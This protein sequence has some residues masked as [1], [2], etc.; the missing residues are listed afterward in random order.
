MPDTKQEQQ[1]LESFK[2]DAFMSIYS[3]SANLEVTPWD[4][5]FVFGA[6]ISQG[7]N[8]SPK[9]ESRVEVVMSPQHAK[10]MLNVLSTH[11]QQY[12]KQVGEVK[13][14]QPQP[15]AEQPLVKAQ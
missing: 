13:L 2:S 7:P 3:N 15:T 6:L 1:Q 12:E 14:P 11:L 8:K 9:I 10:A 4:F 5:K